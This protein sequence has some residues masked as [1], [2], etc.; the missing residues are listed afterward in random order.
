LSHNEC[1]LWIIDNSSLQEELHFL[2][3]PFQENGYNSKLIHKAFNPKIRT[4]KLQD[5]PVT[6]VLLPF[7]HNT[8]NRLSRLLTRHNIKSVAVP[9]KKVSNFLWPVKDLMGLKTLGVY[10]VPCECG[11]VYIGQTGRSIAIRIK[12]QQR[13]IRLIQLGKSALAEHGFNHSHR[14]LLQDTEILSTKTGYL[15]RLIT[16]ATE[17]YLHPNNIN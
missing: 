11:L 3:K 13:N 1:A 2:K 6:V 8:Y 4:P 17:V 7:I 16:E 10:R 15:D 12:E 14:I 9:L 5:K